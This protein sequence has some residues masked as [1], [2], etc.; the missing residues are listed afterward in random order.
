MNF[1]KKC[2]HEHV[3][4]ISHAGYCPDCGEYVENHWYVARCKCCGNREKTILRGGNPM[5]LNLYCKNCGSEE[6]IIEEIDAPDIVSINY[7]TLKRVSRKIDANSLVKH[8]IE[9]KVQQNYGFLPL[10]S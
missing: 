3:D 10:C 2:T 1:W 6:Y 5:P 7:A 4:A 8:W 9:V